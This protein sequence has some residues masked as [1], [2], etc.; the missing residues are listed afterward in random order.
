MKIKLVLILLV[1]LLAFNLLAQNTRNKDSVILYL[2]SNNNLDP[3]EG[4]WTL[5]VVNTLFQN[6]DSICEETQYMRSEW[7]VLKGDNQRFTIIDIGGAEKENK[8][9]DF[10]AYFQKTKSNGLYTYKCKFANPNWT[11]KS[12]VTMTDGVILEYGYFVGKAYLKTEYKED[13]KPGLRLRWRFIWTKQNL[14]K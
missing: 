5:H 8:A 3:I 9:T 7:A 6:H 10:I 11:A 14:N 12:K 13:Y 2:K 1:Q 4:I